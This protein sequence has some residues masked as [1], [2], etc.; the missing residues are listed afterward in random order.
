MEIN[1]NL[2]TIWI[3]LGFSKFMQFDNMFVISNAF[4]TRWTL[5]CPVGILKEMICNTGQIFICDAK[6]VISSIEFGFQQYFVVEWCTLV[7]TSEKH[8]S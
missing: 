3:S 8:D 7:L 2:K 1:K 5:R 4:Q 6:T